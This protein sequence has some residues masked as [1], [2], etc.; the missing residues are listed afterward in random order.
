MSSGIDTAIGISTGDGVC[1]SVDG[2]VYRS[3]VVARSAERH[4][5]HRAPRVGCCSAGC[6]LHI[7]A[8]AYRVR[9]S[10]DG[11]QRVHCH[12]GRR[13]IGAAVGIG[14]GYGPGTS[15]CRGCS[16]AVCGIGYRQAGIRRP[17]I[18]HC[19]AGCERGGLSLADG[20]TVNR[21]G[22]QCVNCHCGSGSVGAAVGIGT[23][24]SP[25]ACGGRGCCAAV[26]GIGYRQA[27]I[28][29][30]GIIYSA[31][32]CKRSGLPLADGR[33]VYR[34]RRQ[35]VHSYRGSGSIR[36]TISIGAGYGPG[37]CRCR[38]CCAAV[39]GIGYRQAG[40][41]RPG[42]V[43]SA[44]GCERSGLSLADGRA[45]HRNHR[46]CVNCHCGSGSV[47]ATVGVGAGHGPGACRCR[48]CRAAVCGIGYRQAGAR[49]PGIIHCSTGCECGGLALAD[50]RAVYR[51]GGQG[52]NR[53]RSCCS[54][55]AAV[56]IGTGYSPGACGCRGCR[57]AVG[58]IGYR[59]AGI[60]RPSIIHRAAGC[61]RGG[62]PLADGRAVHCNRGQRVHCNCGCG[63]IG[64]TVGIGTG[65]GVS[66]GHRCRGGIA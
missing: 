55:G 54:V 15:R 4:V 50:G 48:G 43:Y 32:G 46:Q 65:H 16:A 11:R 59:Q 9:C 13:G 49:R 62:L 45:V 51:H 30:P 26:C 5:G 34:N 40:I 28:R 25:G 14:T 20:R 18:I 36:A 61:E 42:I 60:R 64:A 7:F 63:G 1:R 27:G 66:S 44:A 56:G 8:F 21:H 12:G 3:N 57:A 17:G 23:G 29:R 52:V 22:G 19:S 35:R 24:Y 31:A 41:W 53:Y 2:I 10:C 58:G 6:N 38:G 33:T 37:A 39:C 47:G